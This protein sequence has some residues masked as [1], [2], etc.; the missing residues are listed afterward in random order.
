MGYLLFAILWI[1][2]VGTAT[3]FEISAMIARTPT[4]ESFISHLDSDDTM[5]LLLIAVGLLVGVIWGVDAIRKL[6]KKHE[7]KQDAI[8]TFGKVLQRYSSIGVGGKAPVP[9]IRVLVAT[10]DGKTEVFAD[11]KGPVANIC[12][13]GDYVQVKYCP[14]Y[15]SLIAKVLQNQVPHSILPFLEDQ[16]QTQESVQTPAPDVD[17]QPSEERDS[18]RTITIN[19]ATYT[20]EEAKK[21]R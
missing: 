14:G 15:I 12:S 18:Q 8:F 21:L 16:A 1:C 17:A 19:G 20:L 4:G 10:S 5:I 6:R 11:V 2:G 3:Y 13:A 9:L 7:V